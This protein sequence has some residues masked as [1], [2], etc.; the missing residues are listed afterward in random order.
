MNPERRLRSVYISESSLNDPVTDQIISRL[1]RR[2]QKIVADDHDISSEIRGAN[3][4]QV[5][6]LT[7][8]KGETVKKC[9]GTS[10][11]YLCCRYQVINQTLNCPLN[12][13]YCILQYYLNQPATIIYTDFSKIFSELRKKLAAQPERF[14][15]IGTGELSDSLAY[16]GSML[17]ARE[18]I[19]IFAEIP[20]GI[21]ELK[22]KTVNTDDLLG[23]RHNGHTVLAWS[24]NPQP[25]IDEFELN[26]TPL[27]KRLRAAAQAAEAGYLLAF[28]LDPILT[29][30]DWQSL[31]DEMLD[32]FYS[33]IKPDQIAWI[34]MGSLRYPPEMKD[35]MIIHYPNSVLP[36]GEMIR[37]LDGKMRYARPIRVPLYRR[38]YQKLTAVN[39]PP[40]IYFCMESQDV[41]QEVTGATPNDNAHLDYMFAESLY[42][43]FPGL[44][45]EPPQVSYYISSE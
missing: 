8:S 40:F 10:A 26:T 35:K 39:L 43:R 24:L 9:P 11:S 27:S 3:P 28:H 19:E 16:Y 45:P 12:C 21:L 1:P 2:I 7:R 31:Y 36:F 37:G 44:L 29:V 4:K 42:Q 30:P 25:I 6:Y 20:N 17:F 22:T 34:S 38:I 15:R 5:L 14:F 33:K 32:E 18:A 13:V 23:L 41:W